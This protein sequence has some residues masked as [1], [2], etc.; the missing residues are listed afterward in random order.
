MSKTKDE[1]IAEAEEA[2]I[3][4]P[5]DATKADIQELLDA[6]ETNGDDDSR[7]AASDEEIPGGVDDGVAV[8][9][10][11]TQ[12]NNEREREASLAHRDKE[13]EDAEN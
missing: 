12:A 2:G 9:V 11:A 13:K 4:V 6:E 8:E 7:S 1:L 10:A 3:D 5:E